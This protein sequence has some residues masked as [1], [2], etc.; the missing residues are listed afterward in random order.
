MAFENL[1]ESKPMQKLQEFGGKMQANKVCSAITGGMMG[2]MS[3]ILAGAVFMVIATLLNL[4]GFVQTT[5]TI[6]QWLITPYNMTMNILSVA[7]A[8][9]VGYAYSKN[10]ELTGTMANGIVTMVLFLLVAAPMQTVTLAGDAGTTMTVLNT[11][12]LGGTGL[13]TALI[14]PIISVRIIKF[15]Q[16]KHITLS[17]PDSVPQFLQDSFAALVPLVINIILWHGLNT[18]CE[19]FMTVTLPAAIMGLLAVPLGALVNG[20]AIILLIVICMLLWSVGIHGTGVVYTVLLPILIQATATNADLVA[21]GQAPVF[22]PVFLF[23]VIATCGGTGNMLP[24][25]IM[26]TRAKSE[27]LRAVGKAGLVPAIFNISEPMAFGVPVMYNPLIA[28]PFVIN[29]IITVLI[30]WGVY[31]LGFFQPPYILIM[32]A[33]PIFLANFANSMAWQNLF[34]IP[35]AFIVGWVVYYPFFKMYD[36]QLLEQEQGSE[37]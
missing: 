32:T 13:F 9:S 27:Q 26:C 33:L 17:M 25:A 10:L 35:I 22:A 30:V 29:V 24:L 19:T 15:C 28:I 31:A 16:D 2:V 6:Y 37:A 3:M 20:P 7:V 36:K 21:S 18:I 1:Y 12:F 14:L 5:D 8:F 11:S 34:I 4:A 23:G